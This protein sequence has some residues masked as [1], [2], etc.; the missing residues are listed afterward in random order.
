M[1]ELEELRRQVEELA[2]DVDRLREENAHTRLL[3]AL[4]ATQL[5]QGQV[6]G[7]IARMLEN[8][9]DVVDDL[10]AGQ[11]DQGRVLEGLAAGQSEQTVVLSTLA[12]TVQR[13][14]QD[15]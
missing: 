1:S 7:A 15:Q 10:T 9:A 4:G 12:A 8:V 5:D 2:A 11:L 13:L 6:L 3:V 14:V